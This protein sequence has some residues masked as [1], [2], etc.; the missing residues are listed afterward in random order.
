MH[1]VALRS[2][3]VPTRT[4]GL[5]S[6]G[7][8]AVCSATNALLADHGKAPV[9]VR[10]A[11]AWSRILLLPWVAQLIREEH[12]RNF[13]AARFD[14]LH[15]DDAANWDI[16]MA[17]DIPGRGRMA[18]AWPRRLQE[19]LAGFGQVR[20]V[21]V[22]MLEHLG[23]L[24]RHQPRFS[25]CVIE[26][27]TDGA[28]FLLLLEGAVQRVRWCRYDGVDALASA[29]H[30]EWAAVLAAH[31]RPADVPASLAVTPPALEAGSVRAEAI[32]E[33]GARLGIREGFALPES[34]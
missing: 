7:L 6:A 27:D 11:C 18:V 24:V 14:E 30:G 16:R 22:D 19:V 9:E 20:S 17:R 33:L 31:E 25:G 32:Y 34:T 29:V 13:A 8:E 12:W 23:N 26:I 10:L 4:L 2:A 15:G 3:G 5:E 1:T 21:R 28:G